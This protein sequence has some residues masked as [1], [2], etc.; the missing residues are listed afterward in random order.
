M[1][2][3]E[4]IDTS[5]LP[6]TISR[7]LDEIGPFLTAGYNFAETAKRLDPPRSAEWVATQVARARSAMATQVLENAGDELDAELRARLESFVGR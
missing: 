7:S 1:V 2:I 4:A 5:S 3:L 6:P